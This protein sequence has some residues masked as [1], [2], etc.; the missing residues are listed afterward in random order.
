MTI[1]D[2]ALTK[3][4]AA[5]ISLLMDG[6]TISD[7]AEEFEISRQAV[8]V[9]FHKAVRRIVAANNRRWHRV[10]AKVNA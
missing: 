7:I 8:D 9:H 1:K 5:V 6:W 2:A 10:F 4:Q 3:Q